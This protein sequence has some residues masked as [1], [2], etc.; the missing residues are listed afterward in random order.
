M[1]DSTVYLIIFWIFDLLLVWA[2]IITLTSSKSTRRS[3]KIV[4]GYG[5]K[6]N[7]SSWYSGF[8]GVSDGGSHSS[9]CGGCDGGHGGGDCGSS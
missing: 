9:H 3:S 8:S 6:D 1:D 4:P 5:H 7:S 2:V